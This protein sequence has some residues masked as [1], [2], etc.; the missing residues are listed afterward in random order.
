MPKKYAPA[1]STPPPAHRDPTAAAARRLS[2]SEESP[3]GAPLRVLR[4]CLRPHAVIGAHR[5]EFAEVFWC[6]AGSGAHQLGDLRLPLEPGVAAFIRPI[7]CHGIH[8]GTKGLTL[9][10]VSF[11][12][13]PVAALIRRLGTAWPWQDGRPRSVRLSARARERLAAWCVELSQPQAGRLDLD[14]FLLDLARL[15]ASREAGRAEPPAWLGDAVEAFRDPAHLPGGTHRLAQLTGRTPSH[16]NRAI[17]AWYGR[18]ATALVLDL[19]LDRAAA[20][21]RLGDR[22]VAEVAAACGI[23]HLGHFHRRF[24]ARFGTTPRRWRLD[25]WSAGAGRA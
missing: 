17:R 12:I 3:T 2:W 22:S 18:T 19:R 13:Q 6:E 24:R 4:H 7:D 8:A 9:V 25:A 10:N 5:H 21:L 16:L 11:R 14:A 20:D 1:A 15:T 23:P